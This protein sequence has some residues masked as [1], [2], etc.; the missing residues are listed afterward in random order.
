MP[1]AWQLRLTTQF[2]GVVPGPRQVVSV[3]STGPVKVEVDGEVVGEQPLPGAELEPLARLLAA[4]ELA[5]AKSVENGPGPQTH[6][7]VTGELRLDLSG[8]LAELVP[9]LREV[10]RLRDRVGPPENF[11]I[12]VVDGDVEVLVSSNGYVEIERSGEVVKHNLPS[13]ALGKVRALLGVHA[14]RTASTWTA[15]AGT[16]SL[17]IDGD[18]TVSGLVDQT[19]NGPAP[20]LLAEVMRLGAAVAAK[21]RRPINFE[22]TFT[23]QLHGVALGPLRTFTVRSSDRHLVLV[24]EE[25]DVK[26]SDRPLK[27]EE[28]SALLDMLVDPGLRLAT[29]TPPSSEGMVYRVKITG[30]QPMD[31]T[32]HG[33]PPPL[34]VQLLNRLDWLARHH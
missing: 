34:L 9:V 29:D 7:V 8:K 11:K 22:A 14:I 15:P 6:L 12:V 2:L 24:D 5:A 3:D 13:E 33:S 4:P 21:T 27:D 10:D 25:P 31:Q 20:A 28:W 19:I 1:K 17:R 23:Q 18:I 32:Y 26:K 16:A 30:D